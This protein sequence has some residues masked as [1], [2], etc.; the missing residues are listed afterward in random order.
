MGIGFEAARGE[1][2][3]LPPSVASSWSSPWF[4]SLCSGAADLGAIGLRMYLTLLELRSV[5]GLKYE[6]VLV[7]RTPDLLR[8]DAGSFGETTGDCADVNDVDA[9][10]GDDGW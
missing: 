7:F 10:D 2:S 3:F 6:A 4:P 8:L 9:D 5:V 1:R